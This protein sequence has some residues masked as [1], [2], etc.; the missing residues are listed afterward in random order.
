MS[1]LPGYRVIPKHW[2]EHHRPVAK[3]TMTAPCVMKR[4]SDGPP[5]YPLP[6]GWSNDQ[7]IHETVCRV[8]ELKREGGGT[9]GEQPTTDRQ[10]LIPVPHQNADEVPL[11]ELRA[12][13]QGDVVHALGRQFR[14]INIMFGS[15][16]WERDL[17]CVDNQTQ[18]NPD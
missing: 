17:I 5:P 13:E 15:Q 3:S 16:E 18:Q 12:G 2:A 11:P 10:Y 6:E 1:P 7:I 4:I 14:I 8:Q 9:I